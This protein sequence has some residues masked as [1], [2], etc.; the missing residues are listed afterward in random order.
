MTLRLYM[1]HNVPDGITAGLT[2]R[3]VDCVTALSDG[4]TRL[5]DENLL[6][7]ASDIGRVL[8]PRATTSPVA[9]QKASYAP[10]GLGLRCRPVPAAHAA[11]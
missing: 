1:D 8:N 9:A 7:R 6:Q 5:E 3:G 4:T 2:R 10:T 11:G